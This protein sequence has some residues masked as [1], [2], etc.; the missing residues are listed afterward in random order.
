[1]DFYVSDIRNTVPQHFNNEIQ[2]SIYDTLKTLGIPFGRVET[3]D[4]TTMESCVAISAGLGCAVVKTI[5]LCNRQGTMFYL[6]VTDADKTFV[7]RDFC[8]ALGIPRVS[9]A[10]EETLFDHLGTRRGA[11][12]LLSLV[13]DTSHQV[14][15]V[16]DREV[17][18]RQFIGCTD[19]TNRGFVKIATADIVE[20]FLP[21]TGHQPTIIG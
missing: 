14:A 18:E 16:L 10:S 12:T 11:T 2:K 8:S 4:G 15:L 3:D 17:T 21:H 19:G 1:M 6:Y 7:T 9:F 13:N 20:R 5:F